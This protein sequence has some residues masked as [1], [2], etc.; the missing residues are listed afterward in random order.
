MNFSIFVHWQLSKFFETF[1]N[2]LCLNKCK[3]F[4]KFLKLFRLY[5]C[6]DVFLFLFSEN[7]TLFVSLVLFPRFTHTHTH[8]TPHSSI[9]T[10][11]VIRTKSEQYI[12]WLLSTS[13]YYMIDN[14][15]SLFYIYTRLF[16][17]TFIRFTSS[18]NMYPSR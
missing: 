11:R 13:F 5:A 1:K 15:L 17:F 18:L 8:T 12:D 7:L 4:Q 6:I 3:F 14:W 9:L 10:I 16:I 2:K